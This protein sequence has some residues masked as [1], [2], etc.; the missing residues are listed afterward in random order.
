VKHRHPANREQYDEATFGQRAADS[1]AGFMGS[2]RFVWLQTGVIVV[3]VAI[4]VLAV[5]G[6]FDPYPFI[7][8]N[9]LF[10]TQAAYASPL[11]LLAQNRS[12]EHDRRRAE[13][14][15]AVNQEA[16]AIL[17]RLEE[18]RDAG[19]KRASPEEE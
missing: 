18:V 16:L 4:N 15:Y 6:H 7:L 12:S 1:V 3:W 2:W 8:L 13:F 9:L 14:D 10:S 19:G 5:V 17:K 11:I